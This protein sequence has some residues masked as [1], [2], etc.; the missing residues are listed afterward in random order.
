M[1]RGIFVWKLKDLVRVGIIVLVGLTVLIAALVWL[2]SGRGPAAEEFPTGRY[3]PGTFESTIVLNGEPVF[4]RVTVD[5]YEILD[6]YMYGLN[7]VQRVFYPLFE[8]RLE[9]LAAEILRYQSVAFQ[10]QTDYPVTTG[11]LHRAIAYALDTAM[12]RQPYPE[13]D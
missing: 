12:V 6:I 5:Y 7:D 1:I 13:V 9:D 4:V 3:I 11:V 2:L 10:P 8:P